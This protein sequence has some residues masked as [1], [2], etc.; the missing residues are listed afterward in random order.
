MVRDSGAAVTS[1]AKRK[2]VTDEKV[3][4]YGGHFLVEMQ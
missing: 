2:A 4:L 3:N 1:L